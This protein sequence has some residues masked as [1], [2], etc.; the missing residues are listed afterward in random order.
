MSPGD[1]VIYRPTGQRGRVK[2]IGKTGVWV[3]FF[4][5]E[6]WDRYQNFTAQS[7]HPDDLEAAPVKEGHHGHYCEPFNLTLPED[8]VRNRS[9][10]SEVEAGVKLKT[11]G[12]AY[13]LTGARVGMIAKGMKERR[14]REARGEF[15][16]EEVKT[17]A[18]LMNLRRI[19]LAYGVVMQGEEIL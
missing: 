8:T 19:A 11:I 17:L 2:R 12:R 7:C 14:Q 10:L 3:V 5:Q 15:L 16:K 18:T 13:G 6:E 4:C 9:I 1:Y